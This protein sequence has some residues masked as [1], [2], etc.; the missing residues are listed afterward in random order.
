[1][2]AK[3]LMNVHEALEY[4]GNLDV[5][6]EDDLLTM[7]ISFQEED[8][9]FYLQTTRMIETPMKIQEIKMSFSQTIWIEVNF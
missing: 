2:A 3:K 8:W 1:M 4:L 6:S 5:S 9:L 7:R